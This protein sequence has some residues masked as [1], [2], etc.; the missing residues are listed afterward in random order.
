MQQTLDV[1][2][3]DLD[4]AHVGVPWHVIEVV[5]GIHAIENGLQRPHPTRHGV[6]QRRFGDQL[7][8]PAW[9]DALTRSERAARAGAERRDGGRQLAFDQDAADDLVV[10]R[11]AVEVILVEEMAERPMPDVVQQPSHP[12]CLLD[13]GRRRYVGV[14]H[15]EVGIELPRPPAAEV[16]RPQRV[17]KPRMLAT[18]EH[19]PGRLQLMNSP[20]T[21]Q[22]GV[23]EQVLLRGL[24]IA[25]NPL[26]DFDVAEQW[27]GDQVHRV[28]PPG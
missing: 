13:A 25:A 17:L 18:G 24:A 1:D 26:G 7:G 22:P 4:A 11:V 9:V 10:D 8:D 12:E 27:I 5:G 21:L 23:V 16:H 15:R 3:S 20:Q 19:P 2:R 14:Q 28:V 6:G